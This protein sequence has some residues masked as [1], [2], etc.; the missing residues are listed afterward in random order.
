MYRV[1]IEPVIYRLISLA[2]QYGQD[3]RVTVNKDAVVVT[4]DMPEAEFNVKKYWRCE[5]QM[6]RN[7]VEAYPFAVTFNHISRAA[8]LIHRSAFAID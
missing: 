4:T 2:G 8:R 1:I 7:L 6:T 5:R 3:F